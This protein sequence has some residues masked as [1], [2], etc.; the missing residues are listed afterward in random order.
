LFD[1]AVVLNELFGLAASVSV[2]SSA[3][4]TFSSPSVLL[5]ATAKGVLIADD[6]FLT[7]VMFKSVTARPVGAEI[8]STPIVSADCRGSAEVVVTAGTF[9]FVV[10]T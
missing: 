4:V 10:S 3:T 1:A 8:T 5:V 7:D 9:V 6:A 2:S